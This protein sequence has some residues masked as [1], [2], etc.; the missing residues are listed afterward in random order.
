[1]NEVIAYLESVKRLY[2][3][4]VPVSLVDAKAI[5][6]AAVQS[7]RLLVIGDSLTK[8]GLALLNSALTK[9]LKLELNEVEIYLLSD[10]N[11]KT[12]NS[13]LNE[14]P[15]DVVLVFGNAL[16]AGLGVKVAPE[17]GTWTAIGKKKF[18]YTLHP[19]EVSK[20]TDLKRSYWTQLQMILEAGI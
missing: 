18:L 12:L 7:K 4:G 1:V 2:P 6:E 10:K 9:G 20:N 16:C 8:E 13:K 5:E 14:L 19:D 17:C 11:E 15:T 3:F